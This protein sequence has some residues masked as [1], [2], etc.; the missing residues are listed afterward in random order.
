MPLEH[1]LITQFPFDIVNHL[2]VDTQFLK[3]PLLYYFTQ[4]YIYKK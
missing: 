3:A 1:F 2:L 4:R